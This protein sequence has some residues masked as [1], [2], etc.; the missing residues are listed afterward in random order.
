M[1]DLMIEENNK[2]SQSDNELTIDKESNINHN[3]LRHCHHHHR[4]KSIQKT[5]EM[6]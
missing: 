5:L 2:Y 4:N 1:D 3:N 6:I